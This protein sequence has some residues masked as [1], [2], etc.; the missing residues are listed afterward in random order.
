MSLSLDPY[1]S[2]IS[3]PIDSYSTNQPH[4]IVKYPYKAANPD[5]LSCYVN[6]LVLLKRLV[7]DEWI[8]A[9]NTRSKLSGIVPLSFLNIQVPLVSSNT[10]QSVFSNNID[11][12]SSVSCWVRALYDYETGVEGDLKVNFFFKRFA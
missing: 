3:P 5:E 9:T 2:N 6:D 8:F 11:D 12:K 1:K 10:T 4:A 7:D